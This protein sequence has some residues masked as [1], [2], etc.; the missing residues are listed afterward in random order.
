MDTFLVSIF[1]CVF[2]RV[3]KEILQEMA[4]HW[5]G[6]DRFYRWQSSAIAALKEAAQDYLVHFLRYF[7]SLPTVRSQIFLKLLYACH[8]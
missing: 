8:M 3:V 1:Y 6:T 7:A 4:P 5:V 2:V